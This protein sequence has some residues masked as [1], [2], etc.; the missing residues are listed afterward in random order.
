MCVSFL[1]T[2]V[3]FFGTNVH[4]DLVQLSKLSQLA[5]VQLPSEDILEPV[6]IV[7]RLCSMTAFNAK[8]AAYLRATRAW[9]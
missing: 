5:Q 9:Q 6:Y 7:S 2:V 1:R 4:S 3:Y 8:G